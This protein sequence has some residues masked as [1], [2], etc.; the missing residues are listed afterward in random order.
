MFV[1]EYIVCI[2]M[3]ILLCVE[4]IKVVVVEYMYLEMGMLNIFIIYI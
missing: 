3:E 4:S 2:V 1:G